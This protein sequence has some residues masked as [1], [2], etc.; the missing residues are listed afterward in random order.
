MWHASIAPH[1]LDVAWSE[2]V[3]FSLARRSLEGVGDATLGEWRDAT[4][5]AVHLR[6]RLSVR[7]E[8]FIGRA[9]DIRGTREERRRLKRLR[10]EVSPAL[11]QAIA[12]IR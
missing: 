1:P 11:W 10:S 12:A 7:E 6:R 5:N 2:I 4:K 8:E 3:L 9:K